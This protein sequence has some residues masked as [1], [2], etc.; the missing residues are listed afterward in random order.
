MKAKRRILSLLLCGT[1]LFSLCSQSVFAE[2]SAQD[3]GVAVSA[4]DLC[5]H[6]PEHDEDCGYT[7]GTAGSTCAH[8]HADDCYTEVIDCTHE[9]NEDCYPQE[10]ISDNDAPPSDEEEREPE[11][12]PHIC[13]EDSGCITREL[14]CQH[15][16]KVNGGEADREGG[17]GHDDECGY[18]PATEGTPCGY[19]CEICAAEDG[20][21]AEPGGIVALSDVAVQQAKY[22]T[23]Q[24][25][26]WVTGSLISA[27][28]Q[29]YEG[30]TVQLLENVSL[31]ES[32]VITKSMTITSADTT[33]PKTISGSKSG[34]GYLLCIADTDKPTLVLTNIVVDGG[35]DT[36]SATRALIAVGGKYEGQQDNST[37]TGQGSVEIPV[38]SSG[39][40]P[41]KLVLGSGA[42]LQNNNNTTTNGAG[43]GVCLILG[44]ITMNE[45]AVIQNCKAEQGGAVAMAQ[46]NNSDGNSFTMNGGVIQNNQSTKTASYGYGGG[47]VYMAEGSFTMNDGEIKNNSS[48]CCGGAIYMKNN[49]PSASPSLAITGGTI[50]GNSGIYGGGIYANGNKITLSGGS[51]TKNTASS[52]GGAAL[53]AP[54]STLDISGD[55]TIS[56]NISGNYSIIDNLYLD[57]Y[58][59]NG[60]HFP[61]VTISSALTGS[62]GISTWLKP[63]K[64]QLASETSLLIASGGEYT[65]TDS[66]MSKL[67]SDSADYVLAPTE[68]NTVV[69]KIGRTIIFDANGHGTA[70]AAQ[71]VPDGGKAT[72][73]A[74]PTADGW[75]FKGWYTEQECTTGY[76]FDSTVTKNITLYAKWEANTYT[77]TVQDDGHGSVSASPASATMG[78]EITL[79]ATPN[80]GY[81]FKVWEVVSGGVTIT[82]D[83]FTMPAEDV[84]VKATFEAAAYTVTL[85]TNGGTIASGKEVTSYTY[86]EGAVLPAADDMIRTG[87][88]FV[89]WYEDSSFS[90][91]AVTGISGTETG[92]KTF[93]ADWVRNTTPIIPGNTVRYIVEHYK[94]DAS[95]STGYALVDTEYLAGEIGTEVTASPKTYDGFTYNAEKS[96]ASGMLKA[97][98]SEDD[99]V[100]LKLYYD[101]ILYTVTVTGGTGTGE[102][103]EG[104]AVTI[105]AAIPNGK[106]FVG[107]TITPEVTFTSGGKDTAT[108]V[109]T[110]PAEAVTVTANF[111]NSSS[112]G[113][114]SGGGEQT[115]YTLTFETNGGSS[116]SAI[117]AA[118]GKTVDL[119][120][121][122]PTRDGYDFSGWYSDMG[123]TQKIAEIKLNGNKTVYAGWVQ[124]T[125]SPQTGDSFHTGLWLFTFC[126]SVGALIALLMFRRKD[127]EETAQENGWE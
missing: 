5:E 9:H 1:M 92:N 94:A 77:V 98:S 115:Y 15:E 87:Y 2:A 25:G 97:I 85:E 35:A 32:L 67:S 72:S 84:T 8:E 119:S 6:H 22:Q 33:S 62:V 45:G 60:T 43:G 17:M 63:G 71:V 70:P 49:S 21:N 29:T 88:T 61:D 111:K 75:A 37:T 86:G 65:I 107:W 109:F 120:G 83:K 114:D 103:T 100:T 117:S 26:E 54:D 58:V 116:I 69:M 121:Y 16:H 10:D 106:E 36:V 24:N 4:S 41:G 47:A 53:I 76:N 66:D 93:F 102:Y 126:T 44:E 28:Q 89:G 104:A 39:Y 11:S 123:L 91:S 31:E 112:G 51:I 57:G 19:V 20:D 95:S 113:S 46:V 125:A 80:T 27:V 99:I 79:T 56:D 23:E 118:Y 127:G 82:N 78:E 38:T 68:S 14:N 108:A 40:Q 110:M 74:D 96:T 18:T 42:V 59:Y 30:G 124:R 122:A 73:P 50:S 55:I 52:W 105:T 12:C 90:G 64:E 13:D 101:E 3:D 7:E 48:V 81:Q 34:H